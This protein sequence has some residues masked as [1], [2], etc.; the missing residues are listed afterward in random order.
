MLQRVSEE[1]FGFDAYWLAGNFNVWLYEK[2]QTAIAVQPN[3]W[4][5]REQSGRK[6]DLGVNPNE[7]P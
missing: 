4:G 2:G 5:R 3:C 7:I 1:R 6:K